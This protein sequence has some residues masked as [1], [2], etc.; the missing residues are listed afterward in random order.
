MCTHIQGEFGASKS[1]YC[2]LK[3][4]RA[5]RTYQV[6]IHY[7]FFAYSSISPCEGYQP[8]HLVTLLPGSVGL[9]FHLPGSPNL[10]LVTGLFCIFFLQIKM[11]QNRVKTSINKIFTSWAASI[12]WLKYTTY[13]RFYQINWWGINKLGKEPEGKVFNLKLLF[14]RISDEWTSLN[15]FKQGTREN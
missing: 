6:Y 7:V 9:S 3:G 2:A 1:T 12:C 5:L 13:K 14:F 8:V 10:T 4:K 15:S 11:R